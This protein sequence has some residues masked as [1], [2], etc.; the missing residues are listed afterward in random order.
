MKKVDDLEI[1][2]LVGGTPLYKLCRETGG[3]KK[4]RKRDCSMR[5]V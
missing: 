5:I 3:S 4:L 2:S 1:M